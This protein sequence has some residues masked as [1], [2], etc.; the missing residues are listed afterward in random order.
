MIEKIKKLPKRVT[1]TAIPLVIITIL[2]LTGVI[3]AETFA[4]I[5][6][7]IN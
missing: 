3:D 1:F 5:L 2:Y 4:K 6:L 7:M